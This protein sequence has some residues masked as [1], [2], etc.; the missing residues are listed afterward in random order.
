LLNNIYNMLTYWLVGLFDRHP[1]RLAIVRRYADANG[2]Y[3]GELYME[4]TFA[5]VSAYR[6]IG[7]SLD[8]LP[9]E[10]ADMQGITAKQEFLLDTKHDFLAFMPPE[11]I[12]V[13]AID[14]AENDKVRAMIGRLP[15]KRISLIIQNRFI[16]H[17][18]MKKI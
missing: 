5:G 12:R 17:V 15:R 7:V 4:G 13:G 11:T 18:L 2:N 8:S 1:I 14:P 10:W 6:M 3:V 16:E 9:L